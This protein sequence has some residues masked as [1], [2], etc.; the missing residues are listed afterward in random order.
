MRVL[1]KNTFVY[2]AY[3]EFFEKKDILIGGDKIMAVGKTPLSAELCLDAGGALAIPGFVDIHT[4][5]RDGFDFTSADCE[6]MKKMA[7]V[8]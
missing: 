5:G 6:G 3:G 2:N 4:H 8:D 7:E 1:I